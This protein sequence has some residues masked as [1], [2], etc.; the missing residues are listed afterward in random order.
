MLIGLVMGR[1]FVYYH[2]AFILQDSLG[3]ELFWVEVDEFVG[4]GD[5]A[6]SGSGIAVGIGLMMIFGGIELGIW[7]L[8]G[9]VEKGCRFWF[10]HVV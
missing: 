1:W 9:W 10:M 6:G 8:S 7:N 4:D 2:I 5:G 3:L